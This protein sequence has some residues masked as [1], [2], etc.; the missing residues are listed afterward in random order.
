MA[1]PSRYD[2]VWSLSVR[3]GFLWPAVDLYGG[4]AG[5]YDYGHLG[6][7]MKRNWESVWLEAFL[8]LDPNYQLIDTTIALPE[9]ALKASGHVDHF[10]DLLVRCTKCKETWRADHL[11]ED[12]THEA[13]EGLE[14][15]EA[16]AKIRELAVRCPKCKGEL[17]PSQPFNMM[18]PVAV[19]PL[20]ADR[21]YLR[22]ETAQGAYLNFKR[23]FEALRR[24]LPVGL[25]ILGRCFRNEISPRQGTY[26]MREFLQAELQIF[27]DPGTW[28][29]Q[30][31]FD[32]IAA[33]ALHVAFAD[34][35][36]KGGFA[37][38]AAADLLA[39]G[40]P[41]FYV[42]HMA[43]VQDFYLR[44][45]GLPP[46]RFRFAELSEKERAF[47]NKVHFDIELK[48]DSLGGFKE[49][50]GVHYRTD[51]DL[52]GHQ[53]ASKERLEVTVDGKKVLPHVL[54]LSFGVDRNLWAILDLTYATGGKAVLRAPPRLAP[55]PVAV[56]PLMAKDGLDARASALCARL[57]RRV[58]A[59]YDEGGSIGK[60]YARMDEVGTP[61]CVTV[62]HDTLKDGTVTIRERD[63]TAQRR[64]SEDALFDALPALLAGERAFE[65]L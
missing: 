55:I 38:I 47:Y 11:L 20:G 2:D 49:V 18:F 59:A 57:R 1:V 64:V 26:R 22:P 27:F 58:R 23:E 7:A 48:Q 28:D 24:R 39:R 30:V 9:A 31:P 53:R 17:G 19:G 6:A 65:S 45:L 3:R 12:V 35:K 16:D 46:D 44:T 52:G 50:G 63:S 62:D 33:K 14:P 61:F 29:A 51:H 43:A 10:T 56:F 15:A 21:A 25:A 5:F 4:F 36:G 40:L 32:G 13:H 54:E 37:P 8:G 60:R 41:R 42:Y 34:E